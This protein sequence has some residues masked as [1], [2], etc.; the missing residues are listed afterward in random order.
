MNILEFKYRRL[1]QNYCCNA[2]GCN[3]LANCSFL[4]VGVT[5]PHPPQYLPPA[6]KSDIMKNLSIRAMYVR[7]YPYQIHICNL[8]SQ[9]GL[10]KYILTLWNDILELKI[11]SF[12]FRLHVC[13]SNSTYEIWRR[14]NST[15]WRHRINL[16]D[17]C[18]WLFQD[19][20][21]VITKFPDFSWW[22]FLTFIDSP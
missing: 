12:H 15:V 11:A 14:Y 2:K 20:L 22:F 21:Q 9:S 8:D 3:C 19:I 10:L 6:A 7:R 17:K 18:S 13:I 1:H 5:P 16:T 4:S